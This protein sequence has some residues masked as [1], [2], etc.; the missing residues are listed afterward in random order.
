[1]SLK[2]ISQKE[3]LLLKTY[4]IGHHFK[5]YNTRKHLHLEGGKRFMLVTKMDD[6]K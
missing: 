3:K 6:K 5:I 2:N 1:L 4:I